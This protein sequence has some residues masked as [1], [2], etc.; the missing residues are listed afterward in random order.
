MCFSHSLYR[1]ACDIY[2]ETCQ[3]ICIKISVQHSDKTRARLPFMFL[4]LD[5]SRW[6]MVRSEVRHHIILWAVIIQQKGGKEMNHV[7]KLLS[8]CHNP[9][10][11]CSLCSRVTVYPTVSE[12]PGKPTMEGDDQRCPNHLRRFFLIWRSSS[13][14]PNFLRTSKLLILTL[15]LSSS[16]FNILFFLSLPRATPSEV[17]T[18][19]Q[20]ISHLVPHQSMLKVRVWFGGWAS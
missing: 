15:G 4:F 18:L 14:T 2:G 8:F 11:T 5:F 6:L 17:L 7:S 20:A 16:V 19:I 10:Q 9:V 12:I 13:Y 3:H 1:C